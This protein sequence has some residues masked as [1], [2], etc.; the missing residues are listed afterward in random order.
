MTTTIIVE[1]A[2]DLAVALGIDS[3]ISEELAG[4]LAQYF[5]NGRET[6]NLKKAPCLF[7]WFCCRV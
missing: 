4:K 3:H 6:R 7:L 2:V 1:G 5:L